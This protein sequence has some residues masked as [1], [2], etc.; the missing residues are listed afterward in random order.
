MNV[1]TPPAIRAPGKT[2]HCGTLAYTFGGLVTLF[3]WLLWGDF[4]FM[5]FETVFARYSPIYLNDLG[6]SNTLIGVLSGSAA[7]AVNIIF[8]PNL[9][10]WSDR[11]RSRWGRRRPFLITMAPATGLALIGCGF[12]TEIGEF[13]HARLFSHLFPSFT[14]TNISLGVLA[15][16]MVFYHLFNMAFIS[17]YNWLMRDVVPMEV[18]ARF[19]SYF[20]IVG[21]LASF[22]FLWWVFP[23]IGE[24]RREI[25]LT[26]GLLFCAIFILMAIMVKEGEYPQPEESNHRSALRDYLRF[27]HDSLKVPLYRNFFIVTMLYILALSTPGPFG[28]LLITKTLGLTMDDVGKSYA[29][30]A[31]VGMVFYYPFGWA[32]DRFGPLR[33]FQITIIVMAILSAASYFLVVDRVSIYVYSVIFAIPTAGA[34]LASFAATM[35]IFPQ[36]DFGKLSS[37][38]GVFGC[39]A[40][41]IGNYAIGVFMDLVNSNY[42]MTFVWSAIVLVAAL[43]PM[44]SALRHWKQQGERPLDDEAE[45]S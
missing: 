42:R 33:V 14:A 15:V 39:G 44:H 45:Q 8:L 32:S 38:V 1:E 17:A 24:H 11:F 22:A 12:S 30:I 23:H 37:G 19:L 5:F 9:S 41:I 29:L 28:A 6:A 43:P 7:G 27:F 18:M 3:S 10:Q 26:V 35:Q 31:I 25:F 16:C 20:R 21:S 34:A 36:K 13:L 2:Y 40:A 4:A